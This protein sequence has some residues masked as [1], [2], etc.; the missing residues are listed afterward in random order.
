MNPYFLFLPGPARS[1]RSTSPPPFHAPFP[2]RDAVS[3]D[4]IIEVNDLFKDAGTSAEI[5]HASTGGFLL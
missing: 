3:S 4:D 2:G 5:L 1:Q